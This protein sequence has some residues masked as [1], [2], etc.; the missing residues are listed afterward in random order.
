MLTIMDHD[1]SK[2]TLF[3]PCQKEI[4]TTGVAVIY[5][6]QVFP[7][8]RVPKKIILDRDSCFTTAFAKAVCAQ[9]NIKQNIS[10][11]YHPQTNGQLE[12]A[13]A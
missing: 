5:V 11:V 12:Q 1:C 8:Y 4:N 13:N 9:L 7:H 10:T 2:A 6:Q 3:F